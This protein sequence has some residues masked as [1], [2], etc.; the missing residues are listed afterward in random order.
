M[1][2]RMGNVWVSVREGVPSSSGSGLGRASEA[3]HRALALG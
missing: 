3:A 2:R 1:G